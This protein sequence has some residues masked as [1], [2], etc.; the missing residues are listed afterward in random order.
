MKKKLVL[1]LLAFSLLG[2]SA[3]ADKFIMK[4]NL[5]YKKGQSMPYTGKRKIRTE[6]KNSYV[7]GIENYKKGKKHGLN[8]L[9]KPDGSV[10]SEMYFKNG[11]LV[12]EVYLENNIFATE[13]GDIE[14]NLKKE[15]FYNS[16]ITKYFTKNT[17]M[18]YTG[19]LKE[20]NFGKLK[21]KLTTKKGLP[22]GKKYIY[23]QDGTYSIIENYKNGKKTI[24]YKWNI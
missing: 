19:E 2:Q 23:N 8:Q 24:D 3:L 14:A 7:E 18:L 10:R 12:K 17:G 22:H 16:G 9:L 13:N 20:Y 21:S 5:M 4:N 1:G 11:N 15:Y 6:G